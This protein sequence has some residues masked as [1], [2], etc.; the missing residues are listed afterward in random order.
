VYL[1]SN[2]LC[3][4]AYLRINK[5]RFY[6]RT[7]LPAVCTRIFFFVIR[8]HYSLNRSVAT[9][10]ESQNYRFDD[11]WLDSREGIRLSSSKRPKRA[12]RGPHNFLFKAHGISFVWGTVREVSEA[13]SSRQSNSEFNPNAERLTKTSRSEPFKN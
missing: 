6:S 1:T 7:S 4:S 9:V 10:T 2:Y 11:S 12:P 3:V 5:Q 8:N 13:D